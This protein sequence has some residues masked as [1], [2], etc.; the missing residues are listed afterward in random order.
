MKRLIEAKFTLADLDLTIDNKNFDIKFSLEIDKTSH[1]NVLI[2]EVYNLKYDNSADN[3]LTLMGAFLASKPQIALYAGYEEELGEREKGVVST[4]KTLLFTG[5]LA[6]VL[7]SYQDLDVSYKLVALQEQD[8]WSN[9][10]LNCSFPK[11]YTAAKI[12]G[13]LLQAIG[14]YTTPEG[15]K[16]TLTAGS[17]MLTDIPYAQEFSKSNST[18]KQILGDIAKDQYCYYYI[19]KGKLYF[20][21]YLGYIGYKS[22]KSRDELATLIEFQDILSLQATEDDGFKIKTKFRPFEVNTLV[23]VQYAD[24][25]DR[26]LCI[27]K[28]TYSCEVD[29]GDFHTE[30]EVEELRNYG[31]KQ[32]QELEERKRKS[33][34][35]LAKQEEENKE[36]EE[37]SRIEVKR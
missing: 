25:P 18:L 30:I 17:L 1:S 2:L 16:I 11:G 32:L 10:I 34:E 31:A 15:N 9:I 26:I 28:I 27:S 20:Y 4:P 22:G 29:E 35:T 7:P 24:M 5:Q 14:T 23:K 19:D 8:I 12:I 21:P 13:E 6:Q 37:Q 33:E 3:S 36:K